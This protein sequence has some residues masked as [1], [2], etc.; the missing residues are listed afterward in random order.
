[1]VGWFG[2]L[3]GGAD[4]CSIHD[5]DQINQVTVEKL[6]AQLD[7]TMGTYVQALID[8]GVGSVGIRV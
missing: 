5:D 6:E 8:P 7:R 3:G 4:P 1:M 2:F